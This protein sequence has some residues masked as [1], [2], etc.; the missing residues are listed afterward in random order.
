MRDGSDEE[1][2]GFGED[3]DDLVEPVLTFCLFHTGSVGSSTSATT[4]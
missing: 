2:G 3:R 1:S 4:G